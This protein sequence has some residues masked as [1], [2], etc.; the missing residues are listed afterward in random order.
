MLKHGRVDRLVIIIINL[1]KFIETNTDIYDIKLVHHLPGYRICK[2]FIK[3]LLE[4][5]RKFVIQ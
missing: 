2:S 4:L 1:V 3:Y 5:K